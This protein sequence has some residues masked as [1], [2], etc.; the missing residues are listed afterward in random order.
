MTETSG[1][2]SFDYLQQVFHSIPA[3]LLVVDEDVRILVLNPAAREGLGL[4]PASAL[5]R[6]GGEALGCSHANEHE[7][8]CG[9]A[10]AC[11]SCIIRNAVNLVLEG[12]A[13]HRKSACLERVEGDQTTALPILVSAGLVPLGHRDHVLL[14]LE[15]VQELS[16]LRRLLPICSFCGTTRDDPDYRSDVAAYRE[17]H[18][19]LDTLQALCPECAGKIRPGGI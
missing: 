8:G 17:N 9:H 1:S 13:V 7:A 10:L 15:N 18:P 14:T 11:R 3:M 2:T 16:Q 12:G 5:G 4:D 19:D 6:R